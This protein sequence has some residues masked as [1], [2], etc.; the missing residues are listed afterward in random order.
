MKDGLIEYPDRETMVTRLMKITYRKLPSLV[1]KPDH[2]P[3]LYYYKLSEKQLKAE[4]K[5]NFI[6]QKRYTDGIL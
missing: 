1:G 3:L 2:S 5:L 6:D 4:Y